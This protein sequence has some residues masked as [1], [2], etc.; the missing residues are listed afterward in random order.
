MHEFIV[1]LNESRPPASVG[2]KACRLH[3]LAQH[4]Y[5]VPRTHV[6]TWNAYLKYVQNDHDLIPALTTEIQ[7]KIDLARAYAVR[8]SAN[9]EDGLTFSF[10]GQFKSVLD[11]CGID[12][13]L[14][15]LWSI[16]ATT[17]TPGVETYLIKNGVD[18]QQLRMAVLIQEMVSPVV[19]GV[20]FSK[21]PLTGLNEVVV[22]AVQGSGELLVRKG[23]TP[24]RWVFSRGQWLAQ[25]EQ[26]QIDR[27]LVED[28]VA[29]TRAI[30]RDYGRPIDLEWV[31]DGHT[32]HWVQLREITSL[33][34]VNI[35]S[36]HI[37]KEM[38]PGQIRPL[39]WSINI[40]LVVG[41]Q[42]Q[43]LTELI[44]PN[45]IDPN[46]LVKAF[47]YR[48]YF[49]MSAIGDILEVL[50]LPREMFEMMMGLGVDSGEKM[51]MKISG[52]TLKHLPRMLIFAA[53]Q[54]RLGRRIEK[55]LPRMQNTYRQ[56]HYAELQQMS[57]AE[58]L[59]EIDRLFEIT[60]ETTYYNFL[61]PM[62]MFMYNAMLK[63]S[64]AKADVDFQQFDLTAGLTELRDYEPNTHLAELSRQYRALDPAVREQISRSSYTEF[65]R[66]PGLAS[67]QQAV[68]SFLDRF[69][70]LSDSGVDF[71]AVPW[72]EDPQLVLQ[73]IVNYQTT[74]SKAA[75][76]T[77]YEDLPPTLRRRPAFHLSYQ[78]ARKFRYYREA[79]SSLYTYG[80]GLFRPYFLVLGEKFA[81]RN[82]LPSAEDIFYLYRDEVRD[83]VAQGRSE[84][85][86]A[87]L[88][89][90]RRQE[91]ESY[92]QLVAP[93]II[94]GDQPPPVTQQ[95]SNVL[96]GTPTSRGRYTGPACVIHGIHEFGKMREGD[97]LIIPYSDAG[98]T[99]LFSKAGAVI[100]ESGG[101]LSHSSIV[102]REY[103]IPAVV[104]VAGACNLTDG[105]VV[106]IDGYSGEVLIHE[107]G[108]VT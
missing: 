21:N 13:I 65:Q 54:M 6:C 48:A 37:S 96:Y 105:A 106:T 46:L 64:L 9:I 86:Y 71:S 14:Q 102:A 35:Y 81:Q 58:V 50:G 41:A 55:F 63:R 60:G 91:M 24:E 108:E 22:E 59:A 89:A 49:N 5:R 72:R 30:A 3:F 74:D 76:K 61:G 92:R 56:F 104:S 70:H 40:P 18:P 99:P 23:L 29:Q 10:A 103:N 69:G 57:E 26:P 7:R 38:L 39:V 73:M 94:M 84:M 17:R 87:G 4:G 15:A 82:I 107:P 44:G 8:S 11:V 47:Y 93:S 20:A 43:V 27:G 78:R 67:F 1:H 51:R 90:Q 100:A 2:N 66:L 28:V 77:R 16:W 12:N 101:I 85:D 32:V 42:G 19:S 31:Y 98:W 75:R 36:N 52:R 79:V 53:R 88:A 25:P 83:I 34:N 68:A 33:T 45:K 97:V 95:T 62:F 80:Y